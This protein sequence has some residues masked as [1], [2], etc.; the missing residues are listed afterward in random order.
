[1]SSRDQIELIWPK[2]APGALVCAKVAGRMLT[3]RFNKLDDL[4]SFADRM[5]PCDTFVHLNGTKPECVRKASVSDVVSWNNLLID[6]DGTKEFLN[7]ST[8]LAELGYMGATTV[9]DSGRGIHMWLHLRTPD[10]VWNGI[11]HNRLEL[12]GAKFLRY[13]H[14]RDHHVD[15]CTSDL[16]RIVRLPGT[17]NSRSKSI[18]RV[19]GTPGWGVVLGEEFYE[20]WKPTEEELARPTIPS[21]TLTLRAL[22]P[23]ISA[24]ASEY[25]ISGAESP[26]RRGAVFACAKSLFEAGVT[27]EQ[28]DEYIRR[29]NDRSTPEPLRDE[30]V[31]RAI[32]NAWRKHAGTN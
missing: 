2:L 14:E 22:I 3:R 21:G 6:I 9:V 12:A 31:R 27:R 20:R 32:D 1:M 10:D 8:V 16:P 18:A 11:Q 23:A 26:G 5:N 7:V 13:L 29:G 17:F 28:V 15:T 24:R 4:V 30:E 25:I 19:L